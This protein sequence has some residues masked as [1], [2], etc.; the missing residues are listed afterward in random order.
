ME[1]ILKRFSKRV[2]DSY[3]KHF[4]IK[5]ELLIFQKCSYTNPFFM[6]VSYG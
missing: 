1:K 2:L 3:F 5:S 6:E 4:I